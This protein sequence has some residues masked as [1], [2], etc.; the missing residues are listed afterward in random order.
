MPIWECIAKLGMYC[1]R[2][3]LDGYLLQMQVLKI[4]IYL[5]DIVIQLDDLK[6]T[7]IYNLLRMICVTVR[8]L[9]KLGIDKRAIL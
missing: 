5:P 4:F 3:T 9:Y 6:L 2:E 7:S 8:W 1:D